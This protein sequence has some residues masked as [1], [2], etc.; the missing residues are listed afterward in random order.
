MLRTLLLFAIIT[1]LGSL[2]TKGQS[3]DGWFTGRLFTYIHH[4]SSRRSVQVHYAHYYNIDNHF[5]VGTGIG[6]IFDYGTCVPITAEFR[7]RPLEKK[8]WLPVFLLSSGYVAGYGGAAISPRIG[9]ESGRLAR[10]R[11]AFD[12]GG[13]FLGDFWAFTA[14]AGI[15]F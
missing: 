10:V 6:C 7:Y 12:V 1:V 8:R 9:L 4:N 3:D 15:A 13:T 11:F 14:G 5:S 2:P